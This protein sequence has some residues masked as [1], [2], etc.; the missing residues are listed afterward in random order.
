MTTDHVS[1]IGPP[2]IKRHL[3]GLRYGQIA[4]MAS[5]C[6]MAVTLAMMV[7]GSFGAVGAIAFLVAGLVASWMPIQGRYVDEWV[8]TV[9]MF[10]LARLLT[11]CDLVV[12]VDHTGLAHG[13][14]MSTRY[15]ALEVEPLAL[16]SFEERSLRTKS[17]A[18]GVG[19]TLAAHQSLAEISW[20]ILTE[21]RDPRE[22]SARWVRCHGHTDEPSLLDLYRE[23]LHEGHVVTLRQRIVMAL[24]TTPASEA[25]VPMALATL[26]SELVS[27]GLRIRA[28]DAGETRAWLSTLTHAAIHG[29]DVVLN[30]SSRWSAARFRDVNLVSFWVEQFPIGGMGPELFAELFVHQP[31]ISLHV[32]MRHIDPAAALRRIRSRR[33]GSIADATMRRRAG[34]LASTKAQQL[35]EE[36]LRRESRYASGEAGIALNVTIMTRGDGEARNALIASLHAKGVQ[37][38]RL[39]GEHAQRARALLDPGMS[40]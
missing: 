5:A 28:L 4:V 2:E 31:G 9:A 35:E 30:P 20:T 25:D 8:I 32:T 13:P 12:S 27:N 29:D 21:A 37:L 22:Q 19:A 11:R 14:M 16:Q 3:M 34:F 1:V 24:S 36:R 23:T 10:W 26:E 7:H 33:T 15:V 6:L 38:R 18:H 17:F 39:N 40:R